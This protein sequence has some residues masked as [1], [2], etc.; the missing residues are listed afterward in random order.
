MVL[1]PQIVKLTHWKPFL[2]NLLQVLNLVFHFPIKVLSG[3]H[4][5]KA[6][7]LPRYFFLPGADFTNGL[8]PSFGL[9]FKTLVL[10]SV[11][12]VLSQRA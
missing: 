6:F 11:K 9:K 2:A 7:Y 12:N 8:K 4:I 5:E 3:Y 10:N 1:H